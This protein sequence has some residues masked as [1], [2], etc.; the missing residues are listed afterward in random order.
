MNI[1]PSS[2][3]GQLPTAVTTPA[4]HAA[5]TQRRLKGMWLYT[6]LTLWLFLL[7]FGFFTALIV[8]ANNRDGVATGWI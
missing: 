6:L 7:L 5:M 1:A 3:S 2:P 8:M 4:Q